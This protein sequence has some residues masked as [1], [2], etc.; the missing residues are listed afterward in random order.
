MLREPS[1]KVKEHR[2]ARGY[3]FLEWGVVEQGIGALGGGGLHGEPGRMWKR[4]FQVEEECEPFLEAQKFIMCA[5]VLLAELESV[6]NSCPF[7][8]LAIHVILDISFCISDLKFSLC[9]L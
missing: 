4:M 3:S 7:Y 1:T 8:Q 6:S 2:G 9:R 5:G